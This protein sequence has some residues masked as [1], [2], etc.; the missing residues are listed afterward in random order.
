M[1]HA[2]ELSRTPG[3]QELRDAILDRARP[4][5]QDRALDI[6]AGTGLLTLA[7]AERCTGV[8]A[9]DISPA[10]VDHLRWLVAG[11]R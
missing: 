2:D 10:M 1:R 9:I 7:L 4:V 3:F 11:R 6:G 5:S 8:W